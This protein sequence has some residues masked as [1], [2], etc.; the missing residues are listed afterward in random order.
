V[1]IAKGPGLINCLTRDADFLT[2]RVTARW[3]WQGVS[4]VFLTSYLMTVGQAAALSLTRNE[5]QV[6]LE[7]YL[8]E[9]AFYELSYELHHRPEWVRIPLQGIRQLVEA[10]RE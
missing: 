1:A 5:C 7:V 3:W 10:G 4:T 6:L 8:L 2:D 9:K